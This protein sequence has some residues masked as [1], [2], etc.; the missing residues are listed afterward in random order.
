MGKTFAAPAKYSAY[1]AKF[2]FANP[3]KFLK[4]LANARFPNPA[5]FIFWCSRM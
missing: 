5:I 3:A 4:N 2:I 1:P